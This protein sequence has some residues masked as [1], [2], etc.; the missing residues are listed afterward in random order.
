[1]GCADVPIIGL[2]G[3]NITCTVAG[4]TGKA[5]SLRTYP[6]TMGT[7]PCHRALQQPLKHVCLQ[8]LSQVQRLRALVLLGC[9]LDMGGWAT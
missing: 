9:L 4:P 2:A 5:G 1:M 3:N 8:V 7:S 6:L